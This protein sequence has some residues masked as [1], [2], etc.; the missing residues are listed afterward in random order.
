M[1]LV[2][3]RPFLLGG[4]CLFFLIV[5][6]SDPFKWKI[7]PYFCL[8]QKNSKTGEIQP[9]FPMQYCLDFPVGRVLQALVP[10]QS[11]RP[12]FLVTLL[13]H[14]ASQFSFSKVHCEDWPALEPC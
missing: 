1:E 14:A 11:T 2:Y 13:T 4:S 10:I 7:I 6:F 3:N 8:P 9:L 12:G 5:L